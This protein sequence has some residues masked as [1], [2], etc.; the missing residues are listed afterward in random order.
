[1]RR[2]LALLLI[3]C[4]APALAQ[5]K[6]DDSYCVTPDYPAA[7]RQ[8]TI[9]IDGSIIVP[10]PDKP[11]AENQSWRR[12]VTQFVDASDTQIRLRTDARERVSI[13]VAN[14]DGSGISLLFSGCVP[15]FR[16]E[17][18]ATLSQNA[19]LIDTFFGADWKRKSK[20]NAEHF[21][22]SA[23]LA[24]VEGIKSLPAAPAAAAPVAFRESGLVASLGKSVG[25][26]LEA[27]L[28]RVVLLT[29]LGRYEFPNG[30]LKSVRGLAR[31][32]ADAAKIDFA[33]A[34]LHVFGASGKQADAVKNYLEAF[35]LSSRAHLAT[36]TSAGG[37][38]NAVGA[39]REVEIYQGSIDFAEAAYPLRMRLARDQNG[40]VV[41]SWIEVQSAL[42]RYVPFFG[43]LDCAA[44][45][46]CRYVGD[47]I[48]AQI[49]D[50]DPEPHADLQPWEPFG[51]MRSLGFT[52]T[53]DAISGRI[54][55]EQ[56]Y[57]VG[58][59]DGLDFELKRVA[60]GLF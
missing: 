30:D 3:V 19:S 15:L 5:A 45:G 26:S 55:D 49:W 54:K 50:D 58:R 21:A 28:P 38:L 33:R 37:A 41:N 25:Y 10:E 31:A 34:E 2:L 29:D 46:D 16:T 35:A 40:T 60:N 11:L 22:R 14:A 56:G 52:V 7:I 42:P 44:E 47:N 36:L 24:M 17:E 20:E 48:F 6:I 57:I 27:G 51:G 43:I 23:A 8:T 53:G 13:A 12:F 4:S 39:P 32:D 1:M 18:E 59:E 9:I